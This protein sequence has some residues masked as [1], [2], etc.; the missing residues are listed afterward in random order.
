MTKKILAFILLGAA[1]ACAAEGPVTEPVCTT[2][3]NGNAVCRLPGDMALPPSGAEAGESITAGFREVKVLQ[4]LRSEAEFLDFL[5]GGDGKEETAPDRPVWL[6]LLAAL[7]AGAALNLTPCSLPMLPVTLTII[8]AGRAAVCRRTGLLRGLAYAAGQTAAYGTAGCITAFA[9]A[10]F[11]TLNSS[12]AFN[13][14]M[15]AV[16]LLLALGMAGFIDIGLERFRRNPS[17]GLATAGYAATAGY[18]AVTALLAGACVA[19]AVL[20]MLTVAAELYADGVYS[21][22]LLPFA[23]GAGMGI[24]AAL[25]GAGLAALPKPGRFMEAVKYAFAV[26]LLIFAARYL[27]TGSGLIRSRGRAASEAAALKTALAESG[28]KPVL[29]EFT[30]SWCGNC[31]AMRKIMR[32]PAVRRELEKFTTVEFRAEDITA[33]DTAAV[34]NELNISGLPAFAVLRR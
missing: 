1:L 29:V 9:G 19:P 13:F 30:A 28:D 32:K 23:L 24:P 22:I 6:W 11:G 21:A 10:K 7:A 2:D 8:G 4:G 12:P 33:P 27:I 5:S 31:A 18:G 15:A 26:I 17:A 14:A 16:F 34:L 3:E 20:G 25:A